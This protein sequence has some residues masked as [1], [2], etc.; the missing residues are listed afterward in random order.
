MKKLSARIL[1]SVKKYIYY[2]RVRD[3]IYR[4]EG[5]LIFIDEIL[6][7]SLNAYSLM[8]NKENI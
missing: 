1:R 4:R 8:R 6:N 7:V 5:N 3:G 2:I